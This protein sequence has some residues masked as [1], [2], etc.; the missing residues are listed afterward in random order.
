MTSLNIITA[1]NNI[2]PKRPYK[3]TT[4]INEQIKE[5]ETNDSFRDLLCHTPFGQETDRTYSYTSL[6]P[7][8]DN[9]HALGVKVEPI[10][11]GVSI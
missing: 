3:K 4:N 9:E 2:K 5:N 6:G 1:Q 7:A 8:Q 11:S 10:L